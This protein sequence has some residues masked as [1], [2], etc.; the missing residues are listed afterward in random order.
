MSTVSEQVEAYIAYKQGLG[1]AMRSEACTMRQLARYAAEVGHDGPV[2]VGLAVAWARSGGRHAEGYE[3][4]RY[5]MARRIHEYSCALDGVPP[6]MPAG[7]LGKTGNRITPYIYTDE[8][9]SLLMRGAE[10]LYTQYD[11]TKPLA[12]AALIGLIRSTGM[13]PGEAVA[14]SDSDFDANSG[15]ITVRRAKNGRER[16]LSLDPSVV[17]AVRDYRRRRDS[18]R[19]GTTCKNLFVIGGDSPATLGRFQH[20]F[21]EIRCILLRR[22]EVWHRR[23][24][25]PMDLRHTYAVRTIL[26][27]YER[28]EDVNALLPVLSVCMGH[29]SVTETYWY[30]TG[31]PELMAVAAD[32]FSDY[33][34][35]ALP[36]PR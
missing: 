31:T 34:G 13:R 33:V 10:G 25:R 7:L 4:K 24:P 6:S 21:C 14:L 16:I 32:A 9:V 20:S 19:S 8:E 28:G 5:E 15:T 22:G 12:F 29:K 30:L 36:W 27:W 3:I 2:D 17:D 18:A 26:R 11:R 23:P 1:I 35:G